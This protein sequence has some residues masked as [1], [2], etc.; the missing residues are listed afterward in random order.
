MLLLAPLLMLQEFNPY[1]K[2]M[3]N[4]ETYLRLMLSMTRRMTESKL[5]ETRSL[6]IINDSELFPTIPV[7][8]SIEYR[9]L[10][11]TIPN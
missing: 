3:L 7:S 11:L 8:Q 1:S 10:S 4:P 9:E 2:I 5:N 6:L